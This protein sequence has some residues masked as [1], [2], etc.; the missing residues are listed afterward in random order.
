MSLGLCNTAARLPHGVRHCRTFIAVRIKWV[1]DPALDAAVSKEKDLKQVI[2]LKN[3]ILTSPS[4]SLPLSSLSLLRPD[5][6]LPMAALRFLKRY[7]FIFSVFQPSPSLPLQVKLTR[8]AFKVHCEEQVIVNSSGHRD[9]AVK[10]LARVLMLCKRMRL[11]LHI[12]DR[13]K[14]DLGLPH[15]YVSELLSD[16]PDYFQVVGEGRNGECGD[17]MLCLELVSWKNELAVSEMER[18]MAL[19]DLRNVKKGARIGFLL[20]YPKGFDLVSKVKDWVFEW[21]NLPYVSPYENAFHLNPNGDQAEKWT[22][23]V[24]HELLWLLVSKKTESENVFLLG[25]YLGFGRRFKHAL[26]H[27]PGIFYLSHKIRTQTVVLREAYSKDFLVVKHP[28]MGM[29]FRYIHLMNID[30]ESQSRRK[31]MQSETLLMTKKVSLPA[32][33]SGGKGNLKGGNGDG[34][35]KKPNDS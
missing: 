10:R 17:E 22:V 9:D 16:Y 13:F 18:R 32:K 23:A 1:P 3:H 28:L 19:G 7:P 12:I 31:L 26:V 6:N 35:V 5:F 8:P 15:N 27:H 33:I 29:R 34:A 4:K 21:Q 25:E 14:L 11:P 30:K 24:L 2:A 20:S